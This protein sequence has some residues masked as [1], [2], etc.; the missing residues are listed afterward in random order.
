M[1]G[2]KISQFAA[3][4]ALLSSFL[5]GCITSLA[6]RPVSQ[7]TQI[8]VRNSKPTNEEQVRINWHLPV[9]VQTNLPVVGDN[10]VLCELSQQ[11]LSILRTIDANVKANDNIRRVVLPKT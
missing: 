3:T 5:L 7:Q 11:I 6:I 4:T 10:Q 9:T 1:S 8:D 2:T